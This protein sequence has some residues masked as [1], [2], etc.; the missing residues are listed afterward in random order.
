MMWPVEFGLG[1]PSRP[2]AGARG[3][4]IEGFETSLRPMAGSVRSLWVTDH[5]FRKDGP[6]YEAWTTLSYLAARWPEQKV[7]TMVLGQSYRNPALLAKMAATLDALT[8]GRLILGIGA[9]WKEDE[10]RGYGY[11]FPKASV[12]IAQLEEAID[13]LRLLWRERGP[14]SYQGTYYQLDDAYCEPRPSN[15]LPLMIGGGGRQTME[16]AARKADWWN[17]PDLGFN[18]YRTKVAELHETC[19]RE[20]RDP[21]TLRLTWFGRMALGSTDSQAK[22]RG[23]ETWTSENALVGT[24]A[25]VHGELEKFIELGVSYF[26]VRLI[27]QGSGEVREMLTEE[28][29]PGLIQA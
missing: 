27:D 29:L 7:G 24:P 15:E 4:W 2:P 28:V 1:V 25:R 9:G 18:R 11:P 14:V 3:E 20:A 10:Y 5:F 17:V 16:V 19:E 26:M 22:N 23:G 6:L 21:A 13:I 8:G 12:R